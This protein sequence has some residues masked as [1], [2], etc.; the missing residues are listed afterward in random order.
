[1]KLWILL[2]SLIVFL[3]FLATP[4]N[5]VQADK[6]TTQQNF[7]NISQGSAYRFYVAPNTPPIKYTVTDKAT[8]YYPWISVRDDNG[9]SFQLNLN[10][11][12]AIESY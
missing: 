12:W 6:Q 11:V 4:I 7:P 8:T 3:F 2:G 9:K 1:M 10:Q 5:S